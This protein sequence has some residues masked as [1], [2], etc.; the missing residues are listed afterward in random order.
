MPIGPHL[1]SQASNLGKI[2][3][4]EDDSKIIEYADDILLFLN[5][6]QDFIKQHP[7]STISIPSLK[8]IVYRLESE[9]EAA[10][11]DKVIR[12]RLLN[13]FAKVAQY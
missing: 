2:F 6:L 13:I 3:L 7:K 12:T 1:A 9:P 11:H 8:D 4:K 10:L 5:R